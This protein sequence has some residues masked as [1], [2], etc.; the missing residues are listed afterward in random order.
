M[1][2]TTT[3]AVPYKWDYSRPILT[4]ATGWHVERL[5]DSIAEHEELWDE[6][7]MRT[8]YPES[9]HYHASDIWI[10]YN[11]IENLSKGLREFNAPHDAVWYPAAGILTDVKA[12][13]LD[14]AR[15]LGATRIGGTLLT[16]LPAGKS[17]KP[18]NDGASWHA[19]YYNVKAAV[20]I[21]GNANTVFRFKDCEIRPESGD[22]YIFNNSQDHTVVNDS[23]EDRITLIVAIRTI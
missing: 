21:V 6:Y 23:S 15:L 3:G 1:A 4:V 12:L 11:A 8:E 16:K 13:T 20:Q 17:I 14:V 5:R 2:E 18:H 19:T 9:P 22:V 10:R 7:S